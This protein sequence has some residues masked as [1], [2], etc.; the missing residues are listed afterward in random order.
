MEEENGED[1]CGYHKGEAVFHD[2][3]K[4]WNCCKKETHDWDD[5]MKLPTC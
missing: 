3:K 2:L 1:A 4:F 5:F